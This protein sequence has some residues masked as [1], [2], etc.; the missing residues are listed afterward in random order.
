MILVAQSNGLAYFVVATI[1]REKM[2]RLTAG[3]KPLNS[4]FQEQ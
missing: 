3:Q 4:L 2:I 1:V